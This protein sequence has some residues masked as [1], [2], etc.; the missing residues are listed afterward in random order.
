M[1]NKKLTAKPKN[2]DSDWFVKLT[3][4][5]FS[6]CAFIVLLIFGVCRLSPDGGE[7][8]KAKYNEIML[9]DISL[10]QVWSSVKEVARYVIKPVE[11]DDVHQ[12]VAQT[13]EPEYEEVTE[14]VIT[15]NQNSASADNTVAVMS[16][17]GD[18]GK[19]TAPAHGRITSYFGERE[20]PVNGEEDIHNAIDIALDEGTCVAAAWD[21]VVTKTGYDETS[22][23]YIWLIHKN[24]NETLYCHLSE[25]LVNKGVVIRAGETIAFSGNTG[26]STGP[27]LHFAIKENGEFV[28]PLEYLTNKDGKV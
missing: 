27:H 16:F 23:N 21:G 26:T 10:S 6:A 12:V 18:A 2:K 24:G 17:F 20:H 7:S 19:I 4:V 15:E 13:A 1:D 8:I 14:A 3:V 28:D 22:G 5:Q 25:I 9:T 11:V